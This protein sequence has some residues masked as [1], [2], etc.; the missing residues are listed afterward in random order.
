MKTL[1]LV[2]PLRQG[3]TD[4]EAFAWAMALQGELFRDMPSRRTLRFT[5]GEARYFAKIHTGV[6]WGEIFKNLLSGRLPILDATAEQR[7]IE[8][9][10]R[11]QVES[12][13]MFGFG[14]RGINPAKRESFLLTR[15][16]E[17]TQSLEDFCRDWPQQPPPLALRRALLKQVAQ[18][19]KRM[20]E[21]GLNHR[22]FYICHFL[23]DLRQGLEPIDPEQIRL[24]L[25]DL[26]RAQIRQSVPRRWL[27]K[28]LGS[29]Y[30]SAMDIGLTPWEYLRFL[31]IYTGQPL[32]QTLQRRRRFWQQ[33]QRR[34]QQ[35]YRKMH[36]HDPLSG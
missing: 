33:V 28:D 17:Y 7:A 21:S 34:A 1:Y 6:G 2:E 26:H 31:R 8:H 12:M 32:K 5:L 23:L 36:G 35:L 11:H 19:T 29:L 20:H 16:L 3:R 24:H 4:S 30:F 25:I 22:D 13:E 10:D 14:V 18:I 9:L 27:V 15:A